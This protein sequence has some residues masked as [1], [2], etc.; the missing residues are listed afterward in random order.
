M[1]FQTW[2]EFGCTSRGTRKFHKRS[3]ILLKI[4]F[5]FIVNLIHFLPSC[6]PAFHCPSFVLSHLRNG[7]IL[8]NKLSSEKIERVR[9]I[10]FALRKGINKFP[11]LGNCFISQAAIQLK[12]ILQEFQFQ[13]RFIAAG[14]SDCLKRK[15][16]QKV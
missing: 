6:L 5:F 13:F 15:C 4:F 10:I 12:R 16:E 2:T 9:Y 14:S 11:I 3:L 7:Q 1:C 8:H